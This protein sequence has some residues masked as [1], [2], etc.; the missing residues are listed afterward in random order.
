MEQE[1][2]LQ[3]SQAINVDDN[4][5]QDLPVY[6]EEVPSRSRARFWLLAVGIFLGSFLVTSAVL[7]FSRE[8]GQEMETEQKVAEK[9]IAADDRVEERIFYTKC[10]HLVTEVNENQLYVG[11]N[12]LD[13]EKQGWQVTPK[14][15]D[16]WWL[17][18]EEA[19]LC[20][21]DM[22]KRSIRKNGDK[23]SVYTGPVGTEGDILFDLNYADEMLPENWRQQL[24]TG[25]INFADENVLFSALESLDEYLD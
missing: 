8:D 12:A 7:F 10:Q 11:L 21:E 20:S 16:V 18:R 1:R 23:L 15:D 3:Q 22:Q 17:Y 4:P 6:R 2:D 25:G 14:N 19:A 5:K 9:I 13:L 24:E